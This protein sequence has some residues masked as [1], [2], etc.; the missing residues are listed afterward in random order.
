MA[1]HVD[2]KGKDNRNLQN[3]F[4]HDYTKSS[5]V[6]DI[7]TSGCAAS[8][9]NF[10]STTS[11][12]TPAIPNDTRNPLSNDKLIEQ[13]RLLMEQLLLHRSTTTGSSVQSNISNGYYVMPDF[14]ETLSNFVGT[15]SYIEASSW[16]KSINSTA[17][18]HNWPDS[19]KL[20]TIRTKLKGA[21][22]NWYLGRTFSDWE[23]FERLFKETFIGTQ[24]SMVERKKL[25]ISRHQQRNETIV[26]YFH[27]KSRMC[28]ELALNF[29]ESKQQIVEGLYS[30]ELCLYL[31][32]RNHANENELLNDI[33]TFTKMNDSRNTRFKNVSR[34]SHPEAITKNSNCQPEVATKLSTSDSNLKQSFQKKKTRCFNCGSFDHISTG[35]TQP[36]RRPGSCFTCG[37]TEHQITAYPQGKSKFQAVKTQNSSSSAA[38][39]LPTEMVTPA[40][41]INIDLRISDKYVSN[42][43]AMIDTGS[44]VS[45]LKE[46]FY[47]LE[48]TPLMPPS[49]SGIVGI[50]GSELIILNQSFVD[51]YPPDTSEPINEPELDIETTLPYETQNKIKDIVITKYINPD[52]INHELNTVN[53]PFSEIKIELK[54]PSVPS[55]SEFSSPVVLVKKKNGELRLCIDYR[56]LNKRTVRDRYPLPL[57]DDHLDTLRD[58]H[59]FTCI[60][61]KDGFHHI[62]VEESSRKFTSFTL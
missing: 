35:C 8:S 37:S 59:Y 36:K 12:A 15:E 58:K 23:H 18:L 53:V 20:E 24:T 11:V 62:V 54:D 4:D 13:N 31:L 55:C 27:D 7:D 29:C 16:I 10:S 39:M 9:V 32:S 26:E 48:C 49:N 30:R 2:S 28:R 34:L 33:V 56:E 46:K 44:P 47:P 14:N 22:H 41:F 57:I 61:L 45:L 51:I 5:D 38:M 40:Y 43:L 1:K 50:N 3:S 17:D 52:T 6:N 42:I 19:F 60:D 21:A 25:L